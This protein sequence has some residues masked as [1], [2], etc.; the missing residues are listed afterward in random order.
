[1]VRDVER[2]VV[3]PDGVRD[4]E[5]GGDKPAAKAGRPVQATRDV[6]AQLF[7]ARC[8][9]APARLEDYELAGVPPDVPR[10][11]RQDLG[12]LV[13]ETIDVQRYRLPASIVQ[14]VVAILA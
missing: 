11:E 9:S 14:V 10:L 12:V 1:M 3:D 8:R 5:R 2:C 13:V 4:P 7:D 6:L